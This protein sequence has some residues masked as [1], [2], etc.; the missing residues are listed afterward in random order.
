MNTR[1]SRSR[2]D[3]CIDRIVALA[4]AV[5]RPISREYLLSCDVRALPTLL[6]WLKRGQ[7]RGRAPRGVPFERT[8]SNSGRRQWW[9]AG[10]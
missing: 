5:N 9:G 10:H 3:E 6:E 1:P 2:H 7:G 4:Q 8:A